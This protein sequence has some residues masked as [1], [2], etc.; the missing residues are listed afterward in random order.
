MTSLTRILFDSAVQHDSSRLFRRLVAV[1]PLFLFIAGSA[2]PA[3]DGVTFEHQ[4]VTQESGKTLVCDIDGDG[5]NDIVFR[6]DDTDRLLW[7]RYPD[8]EESL[9]ARADFS[10]DRFDIKDINADGAPDIITAVKGDGAGL[11]LYWFE[12]PLQRSRSSGMKSTWPKHLIGDQGQDIEDPRNIKDLIGADMDNDGD[13]D[14]VARSHHYTRIYF[15]DKNNWNPRTVYHPRK[16]GMALAD[17]DL[18]GDVDIILNGFWLETPDDPLNG[19]YL[20]HNIDEKWYKQASGK[21]Q[22]NCC[23]VGAADIN[24]DGLSDVVLAHSEKTG[25]PLSWYSVDRIA[26]VKNGPWREHEIVPR[27]D[28]CETVDIG[29]VDGDGTLDVLAAK[30][31]R[32]DPHNY[33]NNPPYPIIIYY[34]VDGDGDRWCSQTVGGNGIYA[35][36][37]ADLG[38]DGDLDILGPRSYWTGPNEVWINRSSDRPLPLDKWRYIKVDSTRANYVVPGGASWWRWFGL[39]MGDLTG[40]GYAD[41][42]SG[43]YFYRNPGGGMTAEWTRVHFPIE[44][45]AMV[46]VD[47]DGDRFGDVMGLAQPRV[48]WLEANNLQGS[49]WSARAVCHLPGGDHGNTQLYG[50]AQLV[51]GGKPELLFGSTDGI[52]YIEIPDHP[53][54]GNWPKT[55]ICPDYGGYATGD[56]D[57]DGYIDIAGS[58]VNP[59]APDSIVAGTRSVKWWGSL[60]CW[61]K[62]PGDGSGDWTRH[63]AGTATH[64]DRFAVADINNDGRLDIV[65]SEERYPG[66][67]ANADLYWFEAPPDPTQ[68]EWVRH[69]V[70]RQQSMNNLDVADMDSDGDID[71]I[72]CEHNMPYGEEPAPG[73]EK[74]QIWVNDG[75]GRLSER[76]IDREKESHLGSRVCD[77]DNDG[78]LDIVSIAWRDF[79]NLHLWRN[80]AV[81]KSDSPVPAA[82][83]RSAFGRCRIPLEIHAGGY[84]RL[85]RIFEVDVNFSEFLHRLGIDQPFDPSSLRVA[86]FDP[87]GDLLDSN[88]PFQ[89]DI[90]EDFDPGSRAVGTLV[91]MMKGVTPA[92]S[93]RRYQIFFNG[94]AETGSASKIE[95]T[96][97]IEEYEKFPGMAAYRIT[98]PAATY[99]YHRNGGGFASLIDREGHD[100][101]GYNPDTE[102]FQGPCRGIPNIAPPGFHPDGERREVPPK[103]SE[104][105]SQGPLKIEIRTE[106]ADQQWECRWSIYPSRASMTLVK[107][108][109]EPYWILYEGTP[110]G[111]FE[112]DRDFWITSKG[113]I[114]ACG[115]YNSQQERG[116]RW[117]EDLPDPEWVCFGDSSLNRM[118]F[119][120][121]HESEDE[122]DNYWNRDDNGMTVFGFGRGPTR[123][124]WQ[125]LRSVPAHLT[126]GFVESK[127]FEQAVR[128]VQNLRTA[129]SFSLG[130]PQMVEK[131]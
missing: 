78:D 99:I 60:I 62:N 102:C 114:R 127:K 105:V 27:F 73:N 39:D 63:V 49:S 83:P 91:L 28:W 72:T 24:A 20:Q 32:H 47:V 37:L 56:I 14:V 76:I 7:L 31:M 123:E 93:A 116:N 29:D 131:P 98:T 25:Y 38:G 95:K 44:V 111:S 59:D 22:D 21:W 104:I 18:D 90:K 35:G 6:G 34:N 75:A 13:M 36:Y 79:Q 126:L 89:F 17:L 129:L 2:R 48:Y 43:K 77:M 74:L 66:H 52:Y 81:A 86:E 119:Y 92:G 40:D 96:V 45:D 128:Q 16:E 69:H 82:A 84:D 12:N 121:H 58:A 50:R 41:I 9:I 113:E 5:G 11:L 15:Q 53:D 108:S 120:I 33:N 85:D 70:V 65:N 8:M 115:D 51:P 118:M 3:A 67:V 10:G 100:W 55:R 71:I 4:I 19:D 87:G 106:T 112:N 124:R 80:D 130:E 54:E 122:V 46:M 42:V 110:G 103:E 97:A 68:P 64:A 61:W 23:Y 30:F 109:G 117:S 101:I 57:N 1:L 125:R 107:T 88:V 26:D 94:D